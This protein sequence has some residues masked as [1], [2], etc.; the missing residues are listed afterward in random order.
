MSPRAKTCQIVPTTF[1]GISSGSA[2]RTRQSATVQPSR[3]IDRATAMPERHLDQED[4]RREQ[5]VAPKSLEEAAAEL[6]RRVEKL[7]EPA[8]TVP[9]ELV[10]AEGVLHRIVHHRHHR[11]DGGKR[12]DRR[13]PAGRE[14]RPCCR[15]SCSSQ[16]PYAATGTPAGLP[17][18]ARRNRCARDAHR[19]RA[20][21]HRR[22]SKA[23]P[24][25]SRRR[26]SRRVR[27]AQCGCVP[28][29]RCARPEPEAR[30]RRACSRDEFGPHA[31]FEALACRKDRDMRAASGIAC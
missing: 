26:A 11:Q 18:D 17:P 7:L 30:H 1:H 9:E 19:A 6:L 10:V 20:T 24:G 25:L 5:Q 31:E 28:D 4:D 29:R 14:A 22:K 3:G 8:D 21:P 23:P 27:R 13:R 12:D 15:P 16:L 2:I